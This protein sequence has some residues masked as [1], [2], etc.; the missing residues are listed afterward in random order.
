MK[1][2]LSEVARVAGGSLQGEDRTVTG[3]AVDSRSVKPG[4][5]FVAMP[6]ERVDG[7]RYV[8]AAIE[9]GAAGVLSSREHGAV[10]VVV[11]PDAGEALLDLA[12]AH[13]SGLRARVVGITGSVGKT[14]VKDLTAT[15]LGSELTVVASP[16]SY[17]TEVGLPLTLLAA[18]PSTDVVVCEMGS[19]GKGH[20]ALLCDVARPHVG[21]VTS[22]GP[23]HLEMFGSLE[24]VADAKAELVQALDGA[25][26]AVLNADDP[27]VR[28][29]SARTP[30]RVVSYGL[31]EGAD[32]SGRSLELDPGGRP[33]FDISWQGASH[34][35]E[36]PIPGDHMAS[37]ALAACAVGVVLGLSLESCADSLK[38]ATL[39]P[40]RMETFT[41]AD[42][43]VVV[44]DAYN[45]NPMSMAAALRSARW[46]ARGGSCVAVLGEMAELGEV[47][48]IEHERIGELVARLGIDHLVVVGEEAAAIAAGALREGV[49]PDRV[50]RAGDP[51]A[52][53]SLVRRLVHP[54]DAVLVKASRRAALER[55][56]F[57]LRGDAA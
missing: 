17:N 6:G 39:S 10:P 19:R 25:G 24:A 41:T 44:N 8:S 16:G 21:V 42:G 2:P 13:R 28:G 57:G 37:N 36:L 22:V 38:A 31:G 56:A 23:A 47:S 35:V 29:F 46:I 51:D 40:S 55:V 9:A 18:E 33:S 3:V 43:I 53:L 49:E 12:R 54:G 34:R 30:A 14:S 15:V 7:N 1:L 5:L 48:A 52:A 45:A 50:H 11:V 27:V 20:V 32:V 26:T 4:D